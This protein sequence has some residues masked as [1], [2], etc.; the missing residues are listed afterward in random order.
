MTAR[1]V[2]EL[3]VTLGS[4]TFGEDVGDTRD[5]VG[6]SHDGGPRQ[7]GRR[8]DGHVPVARLRPAPRRDEQAHDYRPGQRSDPGQE[9][10]SVGGRRGR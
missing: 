4:G 9:L 10:D 8:I 3:T 1:K 7:S 2:L 5:A 6:L